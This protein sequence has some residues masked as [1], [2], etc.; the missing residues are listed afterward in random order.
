MNQLSYRLELGTQAGSCHIGLQ[1]PWKF[2]SI[3][4]IQPIPSGALSF[5]PTELAFSGSPGFQGT[6]VTAGGGEERL[7]KLNSKVEPGGQMVLCERF[8]DGT[9]MASGFNSPFNQDSTGQ[10][11]LALALQQTPV[12]V[13]EA[14]GDGVPLKITFSGVTDFHWLLA[15][16]DG[17]FSYALQ[18]AAV[19][20]S[21][22]ALELSP[23][24]VK[25]DGQLDSVFQL[26]LLSSLTHL[27]IQASVNS[28]QAVIESPLDAVVLSPGGPSKLTLTLR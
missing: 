25:F 24:A 23:S 28:G 20:S 15:E 12:E 18:E 22:T 9:A 10:A 4:L 14:T 13:P 17:F 2:L 6:L 21:L 27:T 1:S 3:Q 7:V 11:N 5:S 26:N 8:H 19:A 16:S